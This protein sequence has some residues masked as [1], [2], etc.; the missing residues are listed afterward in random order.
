MMVLNLRTMG[1]FLPQDLDVPLIAYNPNLKPANITQVV[2]NQQVASTMLQA[3]GLPVGG[4]WTR[5][6]WATHLSYQVHSLKIGTA[7]DCNVS[8]EVR[9]Q[10]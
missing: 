5:I 1:G 9:S 10:N 2:S 7:P 8:L 6:D 4:S 3:L